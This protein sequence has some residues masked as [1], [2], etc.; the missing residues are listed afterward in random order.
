MRLAVDEGLRR[1]FFR[2]DVIER[3]FAKNLAEP[4][5]AE[6]EVE[7]GH[8]KVT[9]ENNVT[10]VSKEQDV[11]FQEQESAIL[12]KFADE[13]TSERDSSNAE[14]PAKVQYPTKLNDIRVVKEETYGRRCGG[15]LPILQDQR[16]L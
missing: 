9:Q 1:S 13:S 11:K 5:L 12:K 8:Q 10:K 7:I 2:P 16:R 6:D 14:F 4:L 15:V 3:S